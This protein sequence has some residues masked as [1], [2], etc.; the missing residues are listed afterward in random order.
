M[1]NDNNIN[2]EEDVI[3]L[4]GRWNDETIICPKDTIKTTE[5]GHYII[6]WDT[7][8]DSIKSKMDISV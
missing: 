2:R 1:A 3:V 4:R 5:N 6:K 8:L 7:L